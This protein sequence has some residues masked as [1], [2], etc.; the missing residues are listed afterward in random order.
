[1]SEPSE[2]RSTGT[3]LSRVR[4]AMGRRRTC[5]AISEALTWASPPAT[6]GSCLAAR[7]CTSYHASQAK[8]SLRAAALACPRR[9]RPATRAPH[10]VALSRAHTRTARPPHPAAHASASASASLPGQQSTRTSSIVSRSTR[11]TDRRGQQ[12]EHQR[13][14]L[15]CRP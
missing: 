8:A 5:V 10:V 12:A 7:L 11:P 4:A 15:S 6:S 13:P 2:I 14:G 3:D 9:D 1:V